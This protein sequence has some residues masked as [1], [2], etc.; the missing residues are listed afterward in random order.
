MARQGRNSAVEVVDGYVDN[1][2]K[3]KDLAITL[4]SETSIDVNR[5]FDNCILE[6]VEQNIVK[7]NEISDKAWLLSSILLYSVVFDKSAYMQSGLSWRDYIKDGKE[8]LGMAARDISESLSAARFF[9]KNYKSL[10]RAGWTPSGSARKLARAELALEL[11]GSLDDVI[12]HLVSDSFRDFV[13]W[14]QSFTARS[15]LPVSEK[16]DVEYKGND[17]IVNGKKAITLSGDI[18]EGTQKKLHKY[19]EQ[20]FSALQAGLE[21]AIVPCYDEKEANVMIRLRDKNRKKK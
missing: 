17:I 14:Y 9:I 19:L 5:V 4:V 11:S 13:A 1:F 6:E 18:E 8:R 3:A 20:I 10:E 7:L 12:K 2:A 15:A 21:P 16:M